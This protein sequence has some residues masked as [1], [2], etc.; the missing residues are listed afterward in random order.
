MMRRIDLL[1]STYQERRRQR[2][3]VGL[4]VVAGMLVL[5]LMIGW[6]ILLGTQVNSEKDKLAEAQRR[7]QTLQA[8]IAELSRFQEL[9]DEVTAKRTALTTV[10]TGDV[11]WPAVMTEIAMVIPGEVWLTGLSASAGMTEGATPVGTETAPIRVSDQ[12]AFGRISFQGKSLSVPGIA[13]WLVSL[14]S[15]KEFGAIWLNTASREDVTGQATTFTFDSTLELSERA[16]SRRFL[17]GLGD[18]E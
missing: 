8:Q 12:Q 9:Q 5:L 11:D 6:W 14:R 15:V 17:D 18:D 10:M 13:K 2:R 1:P 4:V 16:A 3:N 7:N